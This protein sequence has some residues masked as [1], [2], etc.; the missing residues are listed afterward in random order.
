MRFLPLLACLAFATAT[1]VHAQPLE[2]P[3]SSSSSSSSQETI[4]EASYSTEEQQPLL[5]PH[6]ILSLP[7][8][9][10]AADLKVIDIPLRC[11][12]WE[13][14]TCRSMHACVRGQTW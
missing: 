6:K 12:E 3:S 5:L 10:I 14:A 1:L 4:V 8:A 2:S 13:C 11:N 9:V 7:E